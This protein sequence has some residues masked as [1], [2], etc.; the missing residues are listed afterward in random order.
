MLQLS[1][2]SGS[3]IHLGSLYKG[4]LNT[5]I[6]WEASKYVIVYFQRRPSPQQKPPKYKESKQ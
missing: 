3:I 2:F 6:T 5:Y 4:R 1:N